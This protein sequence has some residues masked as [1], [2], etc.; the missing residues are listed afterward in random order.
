VG[1]KINPNL[2]SLGL[3]PID[4]LKP[5]LPSLLLPLHFEQEIGMKLLS[6]RIGRRF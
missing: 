5:E 1:E 2:H 6:S 3:K 4:D